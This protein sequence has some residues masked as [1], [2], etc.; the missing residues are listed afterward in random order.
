MNYNIILTILITLTVTI[1]YV[2]AMHQIR[3]SRENKKYNM[4]NIKIN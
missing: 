1:F 3:K 4:R 2:S